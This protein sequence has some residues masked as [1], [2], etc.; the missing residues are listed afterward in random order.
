MRSGEFISH[1]ELFFRKPDELVLGKETAA[2]AEGRIESAVHDVLEKHP[3]GNVAV[4]THG[5]VLALFV[6]AHIERNPFELWRELSLP[7]FV[8]FSLPDYRL[9]QIQPKIAGP[10]PPR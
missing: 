3:S 6:A 4:V 9:E 7:S 8:V 10:P 5:T 1:I 2:E